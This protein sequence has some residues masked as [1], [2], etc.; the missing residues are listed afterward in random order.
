MSQKHFALDVSPDD[1]VN[2]VIKQI[3]K[4]KDM[5]VTMHGRVLKRSDKLRN[6]GFTDGCTIQ[7]TSRM[8]G[9]GR[10]KDKRSQAEKKRDRDESGQQDQQV[11]LVSSDGPAI[12]ESKK[13]KVIQVIGKT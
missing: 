13:D 11:G 4:N 2:D 8:R 5:Y 7:V 1:K 6:C 3:L 12:F 9:G 10:H